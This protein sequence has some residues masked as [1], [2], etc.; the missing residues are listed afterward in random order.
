MRRTGQGGSILGFIIA[1]VVLTGL[2]GGGVYLVHL[3]STS[4][5]QTPGTQPEQP[6]APPPSSNEETNKEKSSTPQP[7]RTPVQLPSANT[8]TSSPQLPQTGPRETLLTMF[9]LALVSGVLISYVRSR[10]MLASL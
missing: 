6:A 3:Q 9:A 1:A 8:E 10:R 7:Q 5:S 2:L 4:A